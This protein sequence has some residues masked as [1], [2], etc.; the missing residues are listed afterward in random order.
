MLGF[1]D[2]L[3]G[4]PGTAAASPGGLNDR[5]AHYLKNIRGSAE[6][7]LDLINDVLDLAKV[8]AG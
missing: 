3:L 5:Q 1:S 2:L 7:L 8:E 6:R 4:V